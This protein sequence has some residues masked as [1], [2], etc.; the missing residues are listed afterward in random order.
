MPS[1]T[2]RRQAKPTARWPMS[3]LVNALAN[4]LFQTHH[5]L[6]SASWVLSWGTAWRTQTRWSCGRPNLATLPM[7]HRYSSYIMTSRYSVCPFVLVFIMLMKPHVFH[8]SADFWAVFDSSKGTQCRAQ[9][10]PGVT[11]CCCSKTCYAY[12]VS[13]LKM[14]SGPAPTYYKLIFCCIIMHGKVRPIP[15]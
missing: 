4:S 13:L 12:E 14:G 2:I 15:L 7:V 9:R 10:N 11:Y 3:F 8:K 6:S 5:C 1:C